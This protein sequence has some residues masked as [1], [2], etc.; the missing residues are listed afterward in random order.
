MS[1][2][3]RPVILDNS[4]QLL[5]MSYR[6][7]YQTFCLERLFFGKDQYPRQLETDTFDLASAHVG[8]LDADDDLVATARVVT[9][10]PAG[11]PLMRH[12]TLF[13]TDTTLDDPANLVVELSRVCLSRGWNRRSGGALPDERTAG[14]PLPSART[15]GRPATDPFSSLIKGVYQVTKH[16][17]ATH[18]IVAVEK[19]LRR[20]LQRYGLPFHQAG[21]EV[22][23]YGPV[24]PYILSLAEFE[25]VIRS[26][27]YPALD[28]ISVG[29]EPEYWPS[30][31]AGTLIPYEVAA[32]AE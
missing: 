3:Y 25:E 17:R 7:R 6:L 10:G 11:L 29:L 20:R 1:G 28:G 2:P 9:R 8:V 16:L 14:G 13:P 5:A 18:W 21:P 27:K 24:A 22:D 15:P 19:A 26:R 31:L 12:C 23:Y 30:P 32:E 4:E